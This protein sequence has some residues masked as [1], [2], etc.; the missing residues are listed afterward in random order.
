MLKHTNLRTK[1]T[2]L[3]GGGR[4][5][6]PSPSPVSQQESKTWLLVIR[7]YRCLYFLSSFGRTET[8][9]ELNHQD[10]SEALAR[11]SLKSSK[12]RQIHTGV[13]LSQETV[14]IPLA[15][16]LTANYLWNFPEGFLCSWAQVDLKSWGTKIQDCL[17]AQSMAMVTTN[18][19]NSPLRCGVFIS[20]PTSQR[21]EPQLST[22]CFVNLCPVLTFIV[23][24]S[25]P[26]FFPLLVLTGITP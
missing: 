5:P 4:K 11:A 9:E 19:S 10:P 3:Q 16:A 8:E 6:C 20:P 24:F 18:P 13:G 12:S 21:K 26:L 23:F 7:V 17:L 1:S 2:E 22:V 25:G 14:D 15:T